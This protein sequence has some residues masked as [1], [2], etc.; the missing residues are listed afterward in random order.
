MGIPFRFQ[1]H[2]VGFETGLALTEHDKVKLPP[3]FGVATDDDILT[4]SISNN[5]NLYVNA[6]SFSV[7]VMFLLTV[8]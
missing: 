3:F 4:L 6:A 8:V 2:W 7:L 5:N 1:V